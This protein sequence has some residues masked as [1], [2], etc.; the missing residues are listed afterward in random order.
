MSGLVAAANLSCVDSFGKLARHCDGGEVREFGSV[1]AFVTGVPIGFF[2]GCLT[3]GGDPA[4]VNRAIDWL[5]GRQ[6]PYL[7][8][9]DADD[10][11]G[12]VGDVARG[13]GLRHEAWALPG[14][15][16]RQPVE[17]PA[18]P[19][20]VRIEPASLEPWL[21]I[22]ESN[23]M[24]IH[25]ARRLF[26]PSF[27]ADPD[28]ELFA[29][30][31]DDRPVGTAVAIRTGDISGVYAVLTAP[32]ARRQGVGTAAAWAAVDAGREWG[33]EQ[34]AQQSTEMGFSSYRRMGFETVIR[35]ATFA[36]P[37]S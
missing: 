13:R 29:G 19:T 16:L 30:Y 31:L 3:M 35:Y 21:A 1:V 14:M 25:L 12:D 11:A 33:C 32:P 28:V 18:P 7:L 36:S 15:V 9:L 24:P 34:V 10:A 17:V 5:V 2:N 23:G 27:A 4:D 22:V 20:R 8:W 26:T 37:D 6:L